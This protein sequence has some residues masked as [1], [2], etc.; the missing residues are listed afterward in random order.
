MSFN[1]E[2]PFCRSDLLLGAAAERLKNANAI[3]FGLGGVG[4]WCLE[5]LV[6]SGLGHVTAVDGDIVRPSNINRQTAATS[7]TSG[8]P[9]ASAMTN[10]LLEINPGLDI[11]PVDAFYREETASEFDLGKFD[12]VFDAID[13]IPD[14]ALLICNALKSKAPLLVSSM[15]AALKRD[16]LH[17]KISRFSKVCGDPLARALKNR[18]KRTENYP[19]RDFMCVWSDEPPRR[20][21]FTRSAETD[22]RING[23]FMPV[24]AAFGLAMASAAINSLS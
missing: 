21:A 12:F 9:K 8:M 16:P 22:E 3:I 17:T 1:E 13:S 24:T 19:A 10:R 18:F 6:R 11:T 20:E 23:S 4:G 14:K 5:A 15:G 7:K 2:T